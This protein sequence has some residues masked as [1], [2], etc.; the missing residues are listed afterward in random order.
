MTYT[1]EL[2]HPILGDAT[3]FYSGGLDS[4]AVAYMT[5]LQEKGRVHLFTIDHGYG[6]LFARWASG[7]YRSLARA[8]GA[9]RL[10]HQ[11]HSTRRLFTRL[12]VGDLVRDRLRYGQW[13][14]CCLGCTLATLTEALIYNLE[15]GVPHIM[16]G[17]SVGG[18]Y[19]VMSMPVSVQLF[20]RICGD[21]GVIYSAPLLEGRIVK[22]QERALL[23]GAGID[24]G[25][26]FKD[27]RSFGN[28]GYCLPSLQHLPDVIFNV[29]PEYRPEQV[30]RFILDKIPICREYIEEH[31]HRAGRSLSELVDS[32]REV[33]GEELERR[34]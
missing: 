4:S 14:G 15:R 12:A 29:H 33:T 22:S 3:V 23:R 34:L 18:E 13:F 21:Y 8:V 25:I 6:Y 24:T 17:S 5:A 19:A 7:S 10:V 30:E 9:G 28:Q 16:M 31:F 2:P 32:L 11:Y 20:K 26:R 27:K 1:P